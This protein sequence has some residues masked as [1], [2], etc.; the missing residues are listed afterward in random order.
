MA[1]YTLTPQQLKGAGIY[2]SFEIPAGGG[3]SF[4]STNSFTFDGADDYIT[5]TASPFSLLDGQTKATFSA[6]IKPISIPNY[7]IIASVIKDATISN[8]QF[9]IEL[10]TAGTLQ[11]SM[12]STSK[13]IRASSTPINL[14]VWTH[15]M[16]C[17]DTTQG[18]G[19]QRGRVFINRVDSTSG[20]TVSGTFSSS[21]GPLY[22]G[23]KQS[24]QYNPFYGLIDEFA[25]WSGTDLRSEISAVYN[26]GIPGDLNNSGLSRNPDLWYRMGENAT[27]NGREFN[28]NDAAGNYSGI[29]NNMAEDAKTTDVPT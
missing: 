11:F 18:V 17:I 7:K 14:N 3:S 5:N 28:I 24:G 27:W 21:T 26:G 9:Q 10:T 23:E 4:A 25:I 29:T 20:T 1:I 19:S 22:I 12:D 2:N 16:Y 6:W 13:Y 15:I 8:H